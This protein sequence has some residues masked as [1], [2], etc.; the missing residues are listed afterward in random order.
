[1]T[2]TYQTIKTAG[3]AIYTE[4]RS[5]FLAF[6][7]HV[8]N[9]A[10]VKELTAQYKK[11]Y[12]DARHVCYAYALGYKGETTRA[13]DDGE[14]SGT[15]GRPILGQIH[16]KGLTFCLVVV[17]RYFG[18]IKLGTS[19]LIVAYKEAATEALSAAEIEEN[20]IKETFQ[21]E[22]PYPELD[23]AMRRIQQHEGEIISR[24]Y[25]EIGMILEI[26]VRC[27]NYASLLEQIRLIRT[28]RVFDDEEEPSEQD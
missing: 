28:I 20:I 15:A 11:K 5:K 6:A 24:D 14:P 9:E 1:M 17:V 27:N 21:I 7:H 12:Y 13:N 26:A 2:D 16:S 8:K 3:E 25:S 4:K 19:G 23:L 22:V 10:E 18:G